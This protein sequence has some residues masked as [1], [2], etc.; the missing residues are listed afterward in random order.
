VKTEVRDEAIRDVV[1]LASRGV[2][3]VL[4]SD[5]VLERVAMEVAELLVLLLV[6]GRDAVERGTRGERV[7]LG[8]SDSLRVLMGE[9]V[10]LGV[11]LLMLLEILR[12]LERLFADLPTFR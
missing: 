5:D 7:A 10:L 2:E 9:V 8:D 3:L 11:D 4:L 12:P 6:V 1:H